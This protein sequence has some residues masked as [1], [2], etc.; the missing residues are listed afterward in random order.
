MRK[1]KLLDYGLDVRSKKV[2][3]KIF[4]QV[5]V[6]APVNGDAML[7]LGKLIL[8]CT[9]GISSGCVDHIFGYMGLQIRQGPS[10]LEVRF[11]E[12]TDICKIT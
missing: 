3:F 7:I 1:L 4:L 11:T 12:A 2:E 8:R 5:L 9:G 6:W 10:G